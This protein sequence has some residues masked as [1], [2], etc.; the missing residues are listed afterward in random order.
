MNDRH[1]ALA[2]AFLN[3]I[4]AKLTAMM[5]NNEGL[6]LTP[7]QMAL[8]LD[9]ATSVERRARGQATD[10]IRHEGEG[11]QTGSPLDLSK[12]SVEELEA[13]ERLAMKAGPG[14]G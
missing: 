8:W 13:F 10:V 5:E 4:G 1:A 2:T 7:S 6:H 14:I 12:L 11:K 9:R 3:Q